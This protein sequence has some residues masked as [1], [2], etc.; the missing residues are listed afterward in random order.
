MLYNIADHWSY[1]HKLGT[2]FLGE[3][4]FLQPCLIEFTLRKSPVLSFVGHFVGPTQSFVVDVPISMQLHIAFFCFSPIIY[5]SLINYNYNLIS[6]HIYPFNS[7]NIHSTPLTCINTRFSHDVPTISAVKK[8]PLR[9]LVLPAA[10]AWGCGAMAAPPWQRSQQQHS[11]WR[12]SA[13]YKLWSPAGPRHGR[14][15]WVQQDGELSNL[16]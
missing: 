1:P 11:S 2:T 4:Q 13:V 12:A 15:W 6:S 3:I 16:P 5:H 9:F 7:I 8:V 10:R 14:K